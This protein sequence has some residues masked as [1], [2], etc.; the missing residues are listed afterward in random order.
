[1]K[2]CRWGV[3]MV[4]VHLLCMSMVNML[5]TINY[6]VPKQQLDIYQSTIKYPGVNQDLN[7]LLII[8]KGFHLVSTLLE[9]KIFSFKNS[10]KM[11]KR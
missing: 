9:F 10:A 6:Y 3:N 4:S 1:M 7:I 11:L 2:Y 8:E 5:F